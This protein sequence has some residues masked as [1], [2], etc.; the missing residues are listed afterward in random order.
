MKK[1]TLNKIIKAF[2]LEV[3]CGKDKIDN[4]IEVYGLNRAGLELTGYYE[5]GEKSHRL[6]LMSTK[7]YSYIMN[8]DEEVRR[9]RYKNLL[10]KNIPGLITTAKFRDELLFK[11]GEELGMPI[12]RTAA[13][14][15]SDFTKDVLDLFDNYFAPQI[16]LHAS[17]VN[18]F[19]KGV[20]LVGESGIGKSELAVDLVKQNHLFVGDDRIVVTKKAGYLYGKSHE[21]L[22]NLVEVRGIG[23]IDISK[24]NGYKVIMEESPVDM[25][26]EL[27]MFK[28]DGVDDSERLGRNFGTYS[29]LGMQLPYIKIPVASGRN[30]Q[31]II[32]TAVAKLKITQSGLYED[33]T[34]LLTDR[35]REFAENE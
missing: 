32:E 14:S 11:V 16:E 24:T 34:K 30:I 18:I 25:V 7:E 5:K 1:L 29:I 22:K 4:V 17:F 13:E 9:E 12:L 26:I 3:V 10:Q 2:D 23:I 21:I 28:K 31:T 15:T 6:I 8:F 19:G 27:S 20:L 35:F 33:D